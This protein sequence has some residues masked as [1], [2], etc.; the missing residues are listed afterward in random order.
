MITL[1]TR[2][3]NITRQN[4][5][6]SQNYQFT[7]F[8]TYYFILQNFK[9]FLCTIIQYRKLTQNWARTE[10]KLTTALK[11]KFILKNK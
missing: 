11:V 3:K 8:Y 10:Q 4:I 6:V 1:K 9:N 5:I 2:K 7:L